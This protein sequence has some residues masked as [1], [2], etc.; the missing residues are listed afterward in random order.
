MNTVAKVKNL[1]LPRGQYIV[2]GG[3][4]LAAHGLRET[5]DLD[6][7]VTLPLFEA[8]REQGWKLDPVYEQKWNRKRLKKEDVEIYPDMLLEKEGRFCGVIEMIQGAEIIDGVAFLSLHELR[9]FKCDSNR[10]KDIRDVM[11]IDEFFEKQKI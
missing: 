2:V 10:E 9:K 5:R 4:C 8:L 6:I 1:N 7:V 11:L 3:S